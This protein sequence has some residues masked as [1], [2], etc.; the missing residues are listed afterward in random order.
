MSKIP[1][2]NIK[3]IIDFL[4]KIDVSKIPF[5]RDLWADF[6]GLQMK[7][8]LSIIAT[9][10]ILVLICVNIWTGCKTVHEAYAEANYSYASVSG[11]DLIDR[12]LTDKDLDTTQKVYR[13]KSIL[14]NWRLNFETLKELNPEGIDPGEELRLKEY[15]DKIKALEQ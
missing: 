2:I 8:K 11:P 4:K 15:E 7:T 1:K 13:C 14:I 10:I 6:K 5:I 9:W 3:I 12:T